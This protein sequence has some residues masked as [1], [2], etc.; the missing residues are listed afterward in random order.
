MITPSFATDRAAG[1]KSSSEENDGAPDQRA[2]KAKQQGKPDR[3][4]QG[5]ANNP[6]AKLR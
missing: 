4:T 5:F 6:F 3:D 1:Q 2:D